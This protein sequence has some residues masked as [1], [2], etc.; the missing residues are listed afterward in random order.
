MIDE[1]FL[2]DTHKVIDLTVTD[3]SSNYTTNPWMFEYE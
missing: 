3:V 1:V 2:G